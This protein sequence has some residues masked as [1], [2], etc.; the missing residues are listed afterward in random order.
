MRYPLVRNRFLRVY[1]YL[2]DI[3]CGLLAKLPF[4]RNHKPPKMIPVNVKRILLRNP[5]VLGDVLYTLRIAAALKKYYPSIEIGLLV[6][7]WAKGLVT[8]S[9]DISYIHYEDHWVMSRNG[10]SILRKFWH[11]LR[12]RPNLLREL[13]AVRYDLAVDLYYY[14]PSG[15]TLFWQAGIPYRIGYDT[16]EC[17]PFFTKAVKW[18]VES[19]HN[20]EYQAALL[21]AV[22][23][24]L[25]NIASETVDFSFVDSDT[26]V[27]QRYGLREEGYVILHMGA[28]DPLRTWGI[29]A[30][31]VLAQSL[32]KDQRLC[33]TGRGV[34]E[35]EHIDIV[36]AHLNRNGGHISLCDVLSL[37]EFCQIIR[38]ARLMVGVDSFAGHVAALYKIPQVAIMHGAV[39]HYHWQP[40]GNQHCIVSRR[41]VACTP[42]YFAKQC[43]RSNACMDISVSD[44][45]N[46]VQRLLEV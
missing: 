16:N 25:P 6:G 11:W 5:A 20:V 42:C 31:T 45:Q 13:R 38:N 26:E 15:A 23:F 36:M 33:F 39:N 30:W 18:H 14:F 32:G 24:S 10:K 3:L 1:L 44:V 19:K 22:N 8:L 21:S 37:G 7:S 27:L 43:L 17:V 12:Q 46:A 2:Q 40:Y 34:Q 35:R 4:E 41:P 29:D 28:G 9:P